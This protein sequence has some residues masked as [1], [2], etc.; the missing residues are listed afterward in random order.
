MNLKKDIF[1]VGETINLRALNESDID[2]NYSKWLNDIEITEY[3]SHGRFPMTIYKL[4]QYVKSSFESNNS[5]V[6][7]IDEKSSNNHIGNIS[8]QSINWVDRNAEIVFLLG[9]KTYWGKG[10]MLEA[11]QLLINHGFLKL[12]L[13][14]IYCGT[15]SENIGMQKLAKKLNMHEEG[16]RKEAILKNG[17]YHDIIEYGIININS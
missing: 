2:G 1:L 3:N 14:R 7:A 15:S 16:R 8:L 6:L 9:E 11:G 12:N 17:K 10:I 5:I 4:K 13:H